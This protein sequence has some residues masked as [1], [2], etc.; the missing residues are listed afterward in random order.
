MTSTAQE[1]IGWGQ[2]VAIEGTPFRVLVPGEAA[3]GR[4]VVLSADM[5]VGMQV[6]E[7]IHDDEEQIS[8][9]VT[10]RVGYRVGDSE[11]LATAGAVVLVPRGV[12]HSLWNAGDEPA[13]LLEIYTPSGFEEVFRAMGQ[14][15]GTSR[16]ITSR[17]ATVSSQIQNKP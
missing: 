5:P 8:I 6:P 3:G 15:I 13:R 12:T 17:T 16:P 1:T 7:H 4:L 14:G 2:G 11:I 9:V 10:G